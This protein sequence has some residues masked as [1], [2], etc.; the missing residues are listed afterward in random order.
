MYVPADR[1][2]GRI[3]MK[4]DAFSLKELRVIEFQLCGV[5]DIAQWLPFCSGRMGQSPVDTLKSA[6][7]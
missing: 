2:F 6:N 4:R 1:L 5:D 7:G 3:N